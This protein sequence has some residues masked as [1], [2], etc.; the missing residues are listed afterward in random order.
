MI[1]TSNV[2]SCEWKDGKMK[3]TCWELVN[4]RKMITFPTYLGKF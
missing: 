2:Q 1:S 4:Y 3:Q